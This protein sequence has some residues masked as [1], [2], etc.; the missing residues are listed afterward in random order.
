MEVFTTLTARCLTKAVI[1]FVLLWIFSKV[2]YNRYFHPL[3][4]YPGPFLGSAFDF[5]TSYLELSGSQHIKIKKWHDTYGD[6]VRIGPNRLS[7]NSSQ[8][9]EEIC[10]WP[11]PSPSFPSYQGL[12]E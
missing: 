3:R 6:V 2:V 5:Y 12:Q 4:S 10:G 8:A 11:T 9:W 1:I 7:Y